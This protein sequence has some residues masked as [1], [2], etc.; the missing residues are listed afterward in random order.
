M[1]KMII[2]FVAVI[3]FK[4]SA[5]AQINN[6]LDKTKTI[7]NTTGLNVTKVTSSI[8]STLTSKLNLSTAQVSKVSGAVSTF[9]QAKS[10][11]IP[12]LKTNK[13]EYEQKQ[14]GLFNSLKTNIA[15]TL[16]KE[17]MNKFLALKPT[18][19]NPNVL[20]NLFY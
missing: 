9:L 12:L 18:T 1:K 13:T 14:K 10:Q 19:T 15:T 8:M 20:S 5:N 2:L 4:I 7:A 6:V 3:C 17:Q 16:A 11:I